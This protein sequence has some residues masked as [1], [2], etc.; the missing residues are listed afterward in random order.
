MIGKLRDLTVNRD[1]TQN[2]TITINKGEDAC[3]LFDRLKDVLCEITIAK[4]S[5]K[6][7]LDANRFLWALCSDI[8]KALT[9]PVEK[10]EIYQRAIKA[11]GVY[12]QTEIPYFKLDEVKRRWTSSGDGWLFEVVD[13]GQRIG[14]ALVHMYFGTSSYTVDE[15]RIVLDWLTDQCRQMEIP[16]PLSAAEEERILKDWGRKHGTESGNS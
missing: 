1:G 5:K 11:A 3:S 14:H 12:W 4:F 7:S 2:I 15:M 16:I 9:P 10:L 8:G 13:K 6:R